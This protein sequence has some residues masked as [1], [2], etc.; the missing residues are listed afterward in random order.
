MRYWLIK[1]DVRLR[2]WIH[3][4]FLV[5]PGPEEQ[6]CAT[7][8][9]DEFELLI[10]DGHSEIIFNFGS[11]Y[12]R[13]TVGGKLSRAIMQPSYLIGGRSHSV[14]TRNLGKVRLAGV[15]LDPRALHS[16]IDVPLAE[17]VDS[18]LTLSDLHDGRLLELE[19][20]L[21][22]A[23][24]APQV[25][26]VLNNFFLS[27]LGRFHRERTATDMLLHDVQK[28]RGAL[29]IMQWARSHRLDSRTMERKFCTAVGMTP[30][31]YARVIRFKHSY[32][33]LISN[34]RR[35]PASAHMDGFYD[36]SHFNREF[37]YFTGAAPS[38][39]LN[40]RMPSGTSISDH[41]LEGEFGSMS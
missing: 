36:Q 6:R 29:S 12:E 16:L 5:E 15:K 25:G 39:K 40:G 18:T 34:A 19:D 38:A 8:R 11:G 26:G 1:P 10:P 31:R 32:H 22:M 2:S 4:Y 24:T 23:T 30:K 37:K 14:L 28:T 9:Y 33:N 41:L 27:A 35:G 13:W 21:A 7:Y 3:C 17:F 20:E